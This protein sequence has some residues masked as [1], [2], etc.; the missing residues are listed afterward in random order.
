[1]ANDELKAKVLETAKKENV[2]F[3]RAQF[4]DINGVLKST[5]VPVDRLSDILEDG[6]GFDGSSI[7]GYT[8]IHESDM[9]LMPDPETFAILPWRSAKE[10]KVARLI[11]DVYLGNK[12]RFDGDPRYVAQRAS[13]NAEE[14]GYIYNCGPE[15]EFFLFQKNE[16]G[17]AVPT[18]HGGYF[19]FHPLDLAEDARRDMVNIMKQNFKIEVEM[20]HHEVAPGQHEVDFKFGDLVPTADKMI[21]YKMVAKTV[22]HL[23]GYIAS[24]MPKP[25]FGENGTGMHTHQSL[26]NINENRNAF[27]DPEGK[28]DDSLSDTALYFIGGLLKHTRALSAVIAPTVNSYKRLVPGYEA[29]VYISWAHKNRSALVRVPEYFPGMENATRA[30]LRCPDPSCNPYMAFACMCAAG[31]DGIKNKI[32][33][34]DAV[35]ADIFEMNTK[36]REN[37]GIASLPENLSHALDELERDRVL[38]EALG[39]HVYKNFM[40]IKRKEWDEYRIQVTKW[41]IDRY[42]KFA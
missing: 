8:P 14:I 15:L 21:T 7:M 19:D 30:E 4:V 29:P 31:L 20:S 35:E 9:I 25:I 6:I 34:P 13:K 32:M 38:Q 24:F 28:R 1:M 3:I 41:E 18:D 42:L 12:T 36:E 23:H 40:L 2:K 10:E 5:A 17:K 22:A 16:D 33:P 11:C 26:W 39:K 27:F 37:R